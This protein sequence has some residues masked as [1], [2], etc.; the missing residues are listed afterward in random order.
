MAPSHSVARLQVSG[1]VATP[2]VTVP[3]LP[4][5]VTQFWAG[6]FRQPFEGH[7]YPMVTV[8]ADAPA[9]WQYC[10]HPGAAADVT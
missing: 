3:E 2:L 1:T 10:P 7:G 8:P 6:H 9:C 4:A 5:T